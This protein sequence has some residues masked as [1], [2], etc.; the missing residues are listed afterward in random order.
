MTR[1][2]HVKTKGSSYTAQSSKTRYGK[3][4]LTKS[5]GSPREVQDISESYYNTRARLKYDG[6]SIYLQSNS[7]ILYDSGPKN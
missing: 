4:Y 6:L 7:N 5:G 1:G 3:R 2:E